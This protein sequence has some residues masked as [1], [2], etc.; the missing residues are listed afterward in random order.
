M[1]GV[2]DQRKL[3][4]V[5]RFIDGSSKKSLKRSKKKRIRELREHSFRGGGVGA[6]P[7]RGLLIFM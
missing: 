3:K 6:M 2:G 1:L 5:T 4:V 7:C